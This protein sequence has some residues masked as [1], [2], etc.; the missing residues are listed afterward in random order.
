[1]LWKRVV[2]SVSLEG[3]KYDTNRGEKDAMLKGMYRK[4]NDRVINECMGRI[5]T[6]RYEE[7]EME[8]DSLR[9]M[10]KNVGLEMG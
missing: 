6:G 3:R 1:M 2:S 7:G 9:R 5:I 8:N 10:R 4:N